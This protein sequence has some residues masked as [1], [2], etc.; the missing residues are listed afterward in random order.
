MMNFAHFTVAL[1]I[2]TACLTGCGSGT[3]GSIRGQISVNGAPAEAGA[4]SFRPAD[5][6]TSRGAGAAISAGQFQLSG[7]HGLKPGK[8]M[9]SAQ[10]SKST[11]KTFNDPQKGPIPVMQSLTLT[12]SPKEVE[13][14]ADN[15][16]QLEIAFTA[17]RK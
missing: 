15:A 4:V 6:P 2:A 14:T 12:D 16:D 7:E 10:V 5:S 17:S 3:V 13:I 9:V 1:A 8:Y 11:G